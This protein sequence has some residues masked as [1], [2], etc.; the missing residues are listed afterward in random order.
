MID[1]HVHVWSLDAERYPWQQT[2]ASVPIPTTPAS[3]E[4]LLAEMDAT[5]VTHALLVQPSV[6]GWDNSYLC[7]AM[8][9]HPGV[10]AGVCLVD[11]R[12]P[13]AG[14]ALRYWCGERGCQGLR[15]NLIAEADADWILDEALSELWETAE[16]LAVTVCLQI[17]IAQTGVV[18]RL[19]GRH[20]GVTFVVDYLGPDAPQDPAM[21]EAVRRL[22]QVPN[23][24]GKLLSVGQDSTERFPFRDLWAMSEA[25]VDAFGPDRLMF[26]SDYPHVKVSCPY[27]D[28]ASW[29]D[30]LPFLDHR[31]RAAVAEG[32]A[33]RLWRFSNVKGG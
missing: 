2:L 9:A 13:I 28:A 10:F 29:L 30:Q 4:D 33:R 27:R 15:I 21:P 8:D 31:E 16:A 32:T 11:P 12:S 25:Q 1:G 7:D 3:A 22:G 24:C 19:A 23:I 18:T 14:E 26:G 20:D 6:Y 17:L 5:R